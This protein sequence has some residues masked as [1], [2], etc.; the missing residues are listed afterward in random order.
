MKNE[1]RIG[2]LVLIHRT[3]IQ[4]LEGDFGYRDDFYSP[5]T[6]NERWL[7]NLGFYKSDDFYILDGYHA[8]FDADN[9]LWFGQAGCCQFETIKDNIKYVHELQNLYFALTNEELT[10]KK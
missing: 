6:L 8:S 5:I 2:N 1:L 10:V 4:M 9:P 7:L 3:E